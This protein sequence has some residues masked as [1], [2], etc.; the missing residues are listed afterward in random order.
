MAK[1]V[2]LLSVSIQYERG[3]NVIGT[4]ISDER[5]ATDVCDEFRELRH[6]LQ[7]DPKLW[8]Q[9]R[10][11]FWQAYYDRNMLLYELLSDGLRSRLSKRMQADIKEAIDHKEYSESHFDVTVRD[12]M[13][14]LLRSATEFDR[15]QKGKIEKREMERT[16]AIRQEER[17]DDIFFKDREIELERLSRES[18]ERVEEKKRKYRLNRKWLMEEMSRDMAPLRM[19]LGLSADE[20]GELLGVSASTYKSLE[21]GKKEVSWDLYLA[22]LFLFRFNDR[23]SAVVDTLG[24]YPEPLQIRMKQ[25]VVS[26]Y[27]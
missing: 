10:L 26:I 8:W 17:Q 11:V 27:A 25:G 4:R 23:T 21:A 6:K 18:A 16:Q 20:M 2:P 9:M 15:F 3:M 22:L 1:G 13:E 14:L 19:L 12:E 24:L 5:A 7:E